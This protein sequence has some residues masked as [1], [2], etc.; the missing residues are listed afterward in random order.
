METN[1]TDMANEML[2]VAIV[3]GGVSGIYSAWRLMHCDVDTSEILRDWAS[4][5]P[6][7][8]LKIGVFERIGGRLLSLV[9]PGMPNLHAE[10]G[11]MHYTSNQRLLRSLVENKLH[12]E[13]YEFPGDK[14]E[15]ILYLR[16]VHL[17]AADASN[18]ETLPYMMHWHEQGKAASQLV[19]E[20]IERILPGASSIPESK[21]QEVKQTAAFDGIKLYKQGFRNLLSRV[22]SNEAYEFMRY[23]GGF[24]TILSNWN[25]ADALPWYLAYFSPEAKYTGLSDGFE[26]IPLRLSEE[27]V[28]SGGEI[29]L[30][31]DLK[32]FQPFT[33]SDNTTG[34][35]LCFRNGVTV[36]CRRSLELL[37]RTG[38]VLD[39]QNEDVRRL[40]ESVT[41]QPLL[42]VFLCYETPWWQATDVR[43]GKSNTDLPV[44]QCYYIGTEGDQ[45]GAD[46]SNRNSL[47]MA[48]Y[49]DGHSLNFWIG[50]RKEPMDDEPET[51]Q[52]DQTNCFC[53]ADLGDRRWQKYVPS[54]AIVNE[55]QRQL[56]EMHALKYIPYPY[57][58]AYMDWGAD[59]F[60][61]AYNLWKIHAKS[62][63]II[64]KMLHPVADVP[65][66]IC[67]EAYCENQGWVDGALQ[68][69]ELMLQN[70]FHL[71]PP[72]WLLSL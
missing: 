65:V 25:A 30:N 4:K 52:P 35:E 49:D 8:N 32:S 5:R 1:D 64:P 60:G 9:P 51:F 31:H 48:S 2:D 39:P 66:Y 19:V 62:W 57:E 14:P 54:T 58:A 22:M 37:D 67:G 16:G 46:E 69:V 42:K 71:H 33:L 38:P 45:P 70:H 53:N 12:L 47:L 29:C 63:E 15:N 34:V 40:I 21:W 26:A 27:F 56:Q 6:D 43:S 68:N 55:L 10:V 13:T 72:D 44:R 18:P 11:A 24:D 50:M 61:G 20:A 36:R 3:G 7:G 23:G 17:R 59:P 28:K 41:P